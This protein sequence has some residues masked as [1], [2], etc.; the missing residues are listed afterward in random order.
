[1]WCVADTYGTKGLLDTSFNK[2]V[3]DKVS[4]FKELPKFSHFHKMCYR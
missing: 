1:M 3:F 4:I 2:A